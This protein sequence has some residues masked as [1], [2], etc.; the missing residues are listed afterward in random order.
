MKDIEKKMKLPKKTHDG[1]EGK[2]D[3]LEEREDSGR[4][5]EEDKR[6]DKKETKETKKVTKK[7]NMSAVQLQTESLVTITVQQSLYSAAFSVLQL[8]NVAFLK[9]PTSTASC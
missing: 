1:E 8:L 7:M 5:K 4:E 6:M 9:Y 2:E 3:K